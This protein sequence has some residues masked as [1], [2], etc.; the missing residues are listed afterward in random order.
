MKIWGGAECQWLNDDLLAVKDG[1]A[2]R[3]RRG[4]LMEGKLL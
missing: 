4:S 2:P 3:C 1:T